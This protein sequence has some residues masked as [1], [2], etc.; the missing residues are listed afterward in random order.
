MIAWAR[1]EFLL[2]S[3]DCRYGA[4]PAQHRLAA[5]C[6][7]ASYAFRPRRYRGSITF[8]YP[9]VR[10]SGLP[11]FTDPIPIWERVADGGLCL[12]EVPGTHAEMVSVPQAQLVARHIDAGLAASRISAEDGTLSPT[13]HES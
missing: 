3:I 13:R 12:E 10:E 8:V 9:S 4:T 6:I 7:K 11:G 5:T 2:T 1:V